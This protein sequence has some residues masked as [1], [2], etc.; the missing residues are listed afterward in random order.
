MRRWN[1][2]SVRLG[3][4]DDAFRLVFE[5]HRGNGDQGYTAID[6]ITVRRMHGEKQRILTTVLGL[7]CRHAEGSLLSL[8]SAI[9]EPL[10]RN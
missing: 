10:S 4:I 5:A 8:P 9:F 1:D 6:D 7:C 2:V 3:A